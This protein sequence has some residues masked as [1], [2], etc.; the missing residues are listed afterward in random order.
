[1][2]INALKFALILAICLPVAAFSQVGGSGSGSATDNSGNTS[3]NGT[4]VNTS[5]GSGTGAAT[6]NGGTTKP[7][8]NTVKSGGSGSSTDS[9]P[10]KGSFTTKGNSGGIFIKGTATGRFSVSI[11]GKSDVL[12]S[13]DLDAGSEFKMCQKGKKLKVSFTAGAAEVKEGAEYCQ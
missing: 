2:K 1:M 5:G 4:G 7:G 12:A 11:V 3:K 6:D 13:G 9:S 8:G 10:L